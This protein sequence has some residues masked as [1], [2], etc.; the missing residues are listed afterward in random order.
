MLTSSSLDLANILNLQHTRSNVK[1]DCK[2]R[3]LQLISEISTQALNDANSQTILDA[4]VAREKLGSTSIGHGIAI[5]HARTAEVPNM[6]A[7]LLQLSTPIDFGS[8]DH[9]PVDIIFGLVVPLSSTEQHLQVL[10]QIAKAC[11][12]KGFRHCLRHADSDEALY[13]KAI[14]YHG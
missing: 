14:D 8:L 7:C 12:D 5:P 3:A 2:K 1:L 9:K 13:Q 10:S 4:L 11:S 6:I